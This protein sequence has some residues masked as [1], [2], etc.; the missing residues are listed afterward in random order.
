MT[1]TAPIDPN[2]ESLHRILKEAYE[3]AAIGK[4]KERHGNGLPFAAQPMQTISE[5]L[6]SDA[7]MAYQVLKKLHESRNLPHAQGRNELLDCII[8]LAGM[9]LYRDRR[10]GASYTI[11][12]S[13]GGAPVAPPISDF[14]GSASAMETLGK[15]T[16]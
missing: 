8:Y 15:S 14:L 12:T 4:G 7:G 3:R 1:P 16:L 5:F 10:Q 9:V 6:E 11:T 13:S 2:Y